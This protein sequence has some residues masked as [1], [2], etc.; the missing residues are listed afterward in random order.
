[1]TSGRS[2]ADRAPLRGAA[3]LLAD[4]YLDGVRTLGPGEVDRWACAGY[5]RGGIAYTLLKAGTL[6]ADREL[7][8]AAMRWAAAGI[9]SG[10]RSHRR[11]WPRSSFSLGLTGLHALHALAARAAGDEATCRRELVRF[12]DS[13]RRARGSSI[14]LFQGMAGRLAGAAIVMR[15]LPD[16][17]VRALGDELAARILER[18][19]AGD[20]QLAPKGLAHGYPGVAL[21]LL[22]WQAVARSL[23]EDALAR[24]VAAAHPYDVSELVE[25]RQM[26]WAHGHAGMALL[27]ARAYVVLGDPRFLAWARQAAAEARVLPGGGLLLLDGATG[28]AY[29]MLAV[30]AAD[31]DGPWRDTAW[32]I[33]GQIFARIE[34]P[35]GNPFGL[36]GGLG[37]VCCLALDL[38]HETSAG[39]PGFEP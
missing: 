21:G 16:P 27:F 18:I 11:G 15:D 19:E 13:A 35:A 23:P 4:S 24:A 2:P 25:R 17:G 5:G 20:A 1:V 6:R 7:V 39:F 9:R 8:R 26:D 29:G 3:A 38:L 36:W 33:A 22:G 32:Q 30:A 28:I 37:G 34:A 31:P 10:R 12:V 14:E